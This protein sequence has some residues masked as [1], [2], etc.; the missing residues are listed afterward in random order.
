M[1]FTIR[2]MVY[3]TQQLRSTSS[4]CTRSHER[5]ISDSTLPVTIGTIA[6]QCTKRTYEFSC[7][8]CIII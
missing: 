8:Q 7:L 3:K 6:R 1:R 2:T 5:Q 4:R